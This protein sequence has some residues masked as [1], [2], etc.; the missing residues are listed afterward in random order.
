MAG[1]E[2]CM[3]PPTANSKAITLLGSPV[4]IAGAIHDLRTIHRPLVLLL[5]AT[6]VLD[7]ASTT[8]FM[9]TLGVEKEFNFVVRLLSHSLG[10]VAGPLLGKLIQFTAALS[11][12]I[13][14]PRLTRF[15][16]TV[17][18]LMNLLAFVINMGIF[19]RSL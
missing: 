3:T 15:I 13:L 5:L 11:L 9:S 19:I 1:V 14:A 10:I 17:V 12:T 7:A 16:L 6:L 4:D 2:V 8:A 18:I